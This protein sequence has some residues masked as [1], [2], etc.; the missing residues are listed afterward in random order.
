[1]ALGRKRGRR[2]R[3]TARRA[4]AIVFATLSVCA[5]PAR[6]H[7]SIAG[8]YD[9]RQRVTI[10][11]TMTQFQFVNPHPFVIVDVRTETGATEEW[12]L[13]LDNRRELVEV[14]VTAATLKPGDRLIVTGSPGRAQPRTMYVRKLERRADGFLYEQ[15]GNSPRISRPSGGAGVR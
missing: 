3:P 6:A 10:D 12:T 2:A 5:V 11:G 4:L 1:M 13:E 7:H 15:I 8:A 9:E 14:G